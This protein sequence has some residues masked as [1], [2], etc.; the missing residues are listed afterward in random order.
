MA[1]RMKSTGRRRGMAL[2]A[3]LALGLAALLQGR[4]EA[5]ASGR[6]E[7]HPMLYLPSGKYL[8]VASL[9]FDGILADII[10]LWSIHYYVNYH[11]QDSYRYI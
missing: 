7:S 10:Y 9:G 1:L 4:M 2:L 3:V 5:R 6:E 11:I 8:R